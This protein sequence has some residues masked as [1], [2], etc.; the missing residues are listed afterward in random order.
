MH[1]YFMRHAATPGNEAGTW[2]GRK[3]EP[4]SKAGKASLQTLPGIMQNTHIERIV[5][6][7]LTRA[8]ETA[9]SI[10]ELY[11]GIELIIEPAL[12]ERDFGPYEGR[13]KNADNRAMLENDTRV[14]THTQMTQRLQ[15]VITNILRE[16]RNTLIVSHSGIFKH[17]IQHMKLTA[18]PH[19]SKLGNLEL[20]TLNLAERNQTTT[21]RRSTPI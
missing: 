10:A 14:E 4:L 8:T 17:L 15:P 11:P 21:E 1:L 18:A 9:Q 16:T 7:P 2:V 20:V 13:V 3:N 19:K 6:S 5:S 12:A